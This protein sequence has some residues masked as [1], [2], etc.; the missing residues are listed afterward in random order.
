[1]KKRREKSLRFPYQLSENV[2]LVHNGLGRALSSTGAALQALLLVDLIVQF[3]HVDRFCR[4][5]S[6]A[7]AAGQALIGD[8]KSHDIPSIIKNQILQQTNHLSS[9][10]SVTII[11]AHRFKK[12]IDN[13]EKKRIKFIVYIQFDS[14]NDVFSN[15]F[16]RLIPLI[17]MTISVFYAIFFDFSQ[18]HSSLLVLYIFT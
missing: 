2:L 17:S 3:A 12:A 4:T 18:L 9:A 11:V 6:S 8:N 16:R 13:F 5:L 15:F 14:S 7:G 1:M 10:F